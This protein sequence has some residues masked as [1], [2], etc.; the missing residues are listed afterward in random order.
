MSM[1]DP[2]ATPSVGTD[3]PELQGHLEHLADVGGWE[4]H[5][6][7]GEV[8]WTDGTERLFGRESFDG[9]LGDAIEFFHPD[10]REAVQM[11]LTRTIQDGVPYEVTARLVTAQGRRRW[12]RGEGERVEIDGETYVRGAIQDITEEK[13]REQRLSVLNRIL[14]HNLRNDLTVVLGYAETLRD[15]LADIGHPPDGWEALAASIEPRA[16]LGEGSAE[17]RAEFAER[18]QFL[19]RLAAFDPQQAHRQAGLIYEN[20]QDLAALA[21]KCGRFDRTRDENALVTGIDVDPLFE[22][23]AATFEDRY[24]R[25]RIDVEG[26]GVT[27]L[28][29]EA[30]LRQAIEELVEN[31]I[32]HSD[33]EHPTVTLRAEAFH[34]GDAL[35]SVADDG[36]GIP[37]MERA[38]LEYGLERPLEHGS[39]IGL[40]M[41][42]WRVAELGGELRFTDNDPR[43]TVVELYLPMGVQ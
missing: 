34:A 39:G 19:E 7:S 29:N 31:A 27:V 12:I 26:S 4:L 18:R 41:V 36:P 14:R 9:D 10:D 40:G 25:A 3:W 2:S 11:A 35:V 32:E 24:P 17:N 1:D 22:T 6:E 38:S 8:Y 37:E 16:E 5:V 43:G 15:Q 13:R 30:G 23:V 28:G 21:E 33:R 42:H 20:A